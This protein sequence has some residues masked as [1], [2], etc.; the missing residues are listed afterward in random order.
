MDFL[1]SCAVGRPIGLEAE[2][3]AKH[4]CENVSAIRNLRPALGK[5]TV[6]VPRR[7]S[8][9]SYAPSRR[10]RFVRLWFTDVLGNLKSF[11]ISPEELEEAFEEGI[12]LTARRLTASPRSR[13]LT[14]SPFP[15]RTPSS[16]FRGVR[17]KAAW[18][19]CSA[20]QDTVARALRG[21]PARCPRA[22]LPEGRRAGLRLQRR[23]QDRV[24]LL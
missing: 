9:S 7:I 16:S 19:A 21:R 6:W 4:V 10:G 13:S 12:A 11:A 23:S 15:W 24:L 8:T 5:G 14:C 17:A 22:H 3:V 1:A 20:N 2:T 18:H